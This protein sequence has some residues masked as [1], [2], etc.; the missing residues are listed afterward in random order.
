MSSTDSA[1]ATRR[2]KRTRTPSQAARAS[3]DATRRRREESD[4]ARRAAPRPVTA[5]PTAAEAVAAR[6]LFDR[7][8]REL[9]SMRKCRFEDDVHALTCTL[10]IWSGEFALDALSSRA[11]F[12]MEV[13]PHTKRQLRSWLA[14][15]DEFHALHSDELP[16]RQ[17]AERPRPL[18]REQGVWPR[19]LLHLPAA[20]L[21]VVLQLVLTGGE[22]LRRCHGE[23]VEHSSS[24]ADRRPAVQPTSTWE[25]SDGPCAWRSN[26]SCT[27]PLRSAARS[28]VPCV[29]SD[30]E[31]ALFFK[32]DGYPNEY[33]GFVQR[34]EVLGHS[35]ET[36]GLHVYFPAQHG[37][38]SCKLLPGRT[39]LRGDGSGGDGRDE[40]R[41]DD[42]SFAIDTPTRLALTRAAIAAERHVTTFDFEQEKRDLADEAKLWRPTTLVGG[43][44]SSQHP[45]LDRSPFRTTLS[46][47]V[48]HLPPSRVDGAPPADDAAWIWGRAIVKVP[49]EGVPDAVHAAHS[50][51]STQQQRARARAAA[52]R[53]DGSGSD[54]D[55]GNAG[56][57]GGSDD[58]APNGAAAGAPRLGQ[59]LTRACSPF[60]AATAHVMPTTLPTL[61]PAPLPSPQARARSRTPRTASL[62]LALSVQPPC[63]LV[64]PWIF[65][66][67]RWRTWEA[68]A[69]RDGAA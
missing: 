36:A 41:W 57:R 16:D 32:F 49:A 26:L 25:A 61:A 6:A 46:P 44:A 69:R 27:S 23:R 12:G 17:L 4:D 60:C 13:G 64:H 42:S 45:R 40:W 59:R 24:L 18:G 62:F 14:R 19:V 48:P 55:A 7:M 47:L 52:R 63:T 54:D 29:A 31:R 28:S 53:A 33:R 67:I 35:F 8:K 9:R 30:P 68:A 1:D 66:M 21:L 5:R 34:P 43:R 37:S 38:G 2:S 10:A 50:A 58:D 3:P 22:H 20:A 65:Q 39:G 11:A 51:R 15:L 56:D